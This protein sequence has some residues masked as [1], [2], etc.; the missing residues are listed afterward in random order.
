MPAPEA[1]TPSPTRPTLLAWL[2]GPREGAGPE[3]VLDRF[4]GWVAATG[5]SPYPAQEE[6]LNR[7]NAHYP[8]VTE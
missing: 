7:A 5:V 1:A 6:A 3:I 8:E 4:L 2:P